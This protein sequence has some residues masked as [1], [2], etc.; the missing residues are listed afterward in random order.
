HLDRIAEACPKNHKEILQRFFH[1]YKTEVQNHF[2]Y[3]EKTVFPYIEALRNGESGDGYSINQFEE[4]HSNI[5]DKLNDLTNIFIKYLPGN[6]MP[7]E[8]VSVLFDIFQLSGDLNKHSLI[9]EK[10][11]IPY[12]ETIERSRK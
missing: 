7:K 11:L 5:E 2:L 3:E 9:E 10:I 6:I 12:V 1:D 4:N 8:R